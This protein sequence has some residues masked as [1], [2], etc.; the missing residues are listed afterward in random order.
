MIIEAFIYENLNR[1]KKHWVNMQNS[2]NF[3]FKLIL[4]KH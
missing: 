2:F 1:K 3:T 4:L